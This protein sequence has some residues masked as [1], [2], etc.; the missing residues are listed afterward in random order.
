MANDIEKTVKRTDWRKYRT[1]LQLFRDHCAG[2]FPVHISED[3][4]KPDEPEQ[5]VS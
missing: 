1:V 2:C 3:I 5:S 4:F